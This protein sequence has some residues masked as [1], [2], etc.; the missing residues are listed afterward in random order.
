[1]RRHP[2]LRLLVALVASAGLLAAGWSVLRDSEWVAVKEVEVIGASGRQREA[3]RS[4][5][6]TAG[7][8]MTTLHLRREVLATAVAPYAAVKGVTAEADFPRRLR[9]RVI[10]HVAVAT[11]VTP[12]GAVPVAADGTVL[13][14][15][16]ADGVPELKLR[17]PPAGDRIADRRTLNTIALVARAPAPLR[18][19]VTTA[20]RGPGGLT[21]HLAEGPSVQF[22]SSERIRAKWASLTAVLASSASKGAT[23]VDVRVPEHPAA[24]GLEQA[25]TQQGEPSTGT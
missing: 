20:F 14:G 9:V 23:S 22:G 18:E 7:R 1:M 8:D 5:L 2:N 16:T 13:R 17:L 12:Q 25:S 10:Q 3:I 21:V 19:K 4:A 15:T 24:A 6:S 11:I